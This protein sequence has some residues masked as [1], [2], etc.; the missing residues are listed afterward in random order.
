M[1]ATAASLIPSDDGVAYFDGIVLTASSSSSSCCCC[2]GCCCR[3]FILLHADSRR[4]PGRWQSPG[5]TTRF[6]LV[7][8]SEI[9]Q[10][11][12]ASKRV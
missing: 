10:T 12:K 1:I 11:S 5:T 9:K 4:P 8:D 6:S 3:L 2:Y 7:N